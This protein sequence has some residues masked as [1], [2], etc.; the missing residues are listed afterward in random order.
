VLECVF[1][2]QALSHRCH[3]RQA[4]ALINPDMLVEI[5]VD[6][7]VGTTDRSAGGRNDRDAPHA[8]SVPGFR[9]PQN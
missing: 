9:R 7:I 5:E 2:E 8:V 1:T 6:A 4:G 3:P